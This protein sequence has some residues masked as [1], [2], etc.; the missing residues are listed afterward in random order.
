M[1]LSCVSMYDFDSAKLNIPLDVQRAR[2]NEQ[3]GI[4]GFKPN[5]EYFPLEY[6]VDAEEIRN[7]HVVRNVR[8][9]VGKVRPS[10]VASI[11]VSTRHII[12]D[13]SHHHVTDVDDTYDK[14]LSCVLRCMY[15]Y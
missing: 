2:M 10:V 13:Q 7:A 5:M 12:T 4:L 1:K 14:F 15:A 11:H 3:L 8:I 6:V 9:H